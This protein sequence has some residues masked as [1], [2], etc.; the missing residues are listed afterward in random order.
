MDRDDVIALVR[1]IGGPDRADPVCPQGDMITLDVD[2]V[3]RLVNIAAAQQFDASLTDPTNISVHQTAEQEQPVATIHVDG[4]FVHVE[5]CVH[6]PGKCHMKVYA[7]PPATAAPA[8]LTDEY[9][10]KLWLAS[11]SDV[12][13]SKSFAALAFH[14]GRAVED[15]V[16]RRMEVSA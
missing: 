1:A 5:W 13:V 6:I 9:F 11:T 3:V 2:E 8:R 12:D 16:R 15:E 10:A 14:Y 7:A 4:S